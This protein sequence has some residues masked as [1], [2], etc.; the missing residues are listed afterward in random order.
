MKPSVTLIA[1]NCHYN[2]VDFQIHTKSNENI[3]NDLF[4]SVEEPKTVKRKLQASLDELISC[5]VDERKVQKL[6]K[7]LDVLDEEAEEEKQDMPKSSFDKQTAK[8][9]L[10]KSYVICPDKYCKKQVVINS[11]DE[12]IDCRNCGSM[13]NSALLEKFP[14]PNSQYMNQESGIRNQL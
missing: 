4:N 13:S 8:N 12:I 5:D 2:N 10:N 7:Q 6:S 11:D 3:S 14:L 9:S 1:D